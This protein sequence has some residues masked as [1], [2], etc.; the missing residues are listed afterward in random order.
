MSG[1]T[2][3]T[4]TGNVVADPE[5][6]FTPG[7]AAVTNFRMA[8]T[9]RMFDKQANEWKDG[10]PLFLSV[11][12]W[13]QQAEHVAETLTRGMRVIVVGQLTQRQYEANDGTKRSSYEIKAEEVAPSLKT[14]TAT[15]TKANGQNNGG[16]S[17]G[18]YGQQPQ[19]RSGYGQ[20]QPQG[21]PW[22]TSGQEPP[23]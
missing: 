22:A 17:T 18:G 6:R 23:F 21:D 14:A 5:L 19:Q 16:T 7:G 2:L 4:F 3:I 8:S 10:E 13:R 12:V 20:Q 9:P 1:E 11:A 15:V